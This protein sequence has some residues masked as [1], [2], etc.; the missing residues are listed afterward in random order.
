MICLPKTFY[1]M[2]WLLLNVYSIINF[3]SAVLVLVTFL[4]YLMISHLRENIQGYSMLCF[5]ACLI[6]MHF[7][8]GVYLSLRQEPHIWCL[9]KG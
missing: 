7:E 3:I 6:I 5:F 8:N 2:R 4:V 9:N 1:V